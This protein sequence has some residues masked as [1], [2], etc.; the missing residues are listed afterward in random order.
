MVTAISKHFAYKSL[1][2]S[3]DNS[4]S[5]LHQRKKQSQ[6]QRRAYPENKVILPVLPGKSVAQPFEC[7]GTDHFHFS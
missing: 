3:H 2:L 1:E 7:F 6:G 5:S 4:P